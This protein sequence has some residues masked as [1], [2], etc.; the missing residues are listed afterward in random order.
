MGTAVGLASSGV[1]T[2]T[3]VLVGL[4]EGE[5]VS[6]DRASGGVTIAT[7]VA[8]GVGSPPPTKGMSQAA[9]DK[10]T[11]SRTGRHF[12]ALDRVLLVVTTS[13]WV[14]LLSPSGGFL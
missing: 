1:A 12:R 13:F 9:T 14:H 7:S 8:V 11:A 6:G 5:G 2:T 4:G 10:T 3:G